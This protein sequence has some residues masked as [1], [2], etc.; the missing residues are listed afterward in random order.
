MNLEKNYF[1]TNFD[2]YLQYFNFI[3]EVIENE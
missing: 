2:I 3:D 1:E